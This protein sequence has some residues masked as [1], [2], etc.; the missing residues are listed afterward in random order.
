MTQA[1]EF[2]RAARAVATE[3]AALPGVDDAVGALLE[4]AGG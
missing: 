4:L 1:A 2:R 3:M